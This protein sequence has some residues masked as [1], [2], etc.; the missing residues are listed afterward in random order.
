MTTR[1]RKRKDKGV[2]FPGLY[3]NRLA[4]HITTVEHSLTSGLRTSC[5]DFSVNQSGAVRRN[6]AM[7]LRELLAFRTVAV[8]TV[9]VANDMLSATLL[10]FHRGLLLAIRCRAK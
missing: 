3:L 1:I 8:G 9:P 5:E 10:N 2:A 4:A 7:G 6:I